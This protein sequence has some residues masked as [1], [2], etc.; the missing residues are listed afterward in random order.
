MGPVLLGLAVA[1][2][3]LAFPFASRRLRPGRH[4]APAGPRVTPPAAAAARPEAQPRGEATG[5]FGYDNGLQ[6]GG[7]GGGLW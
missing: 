5:P 6:V 4:P 3:V 2:V 7:E 1:A